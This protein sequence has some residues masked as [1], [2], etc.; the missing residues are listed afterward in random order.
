MNDIATPV[1]SK[2]DEFSEKLERGHSDLKIFIADFFGRS[3]A[4]WRFSKLEKFKM[5]YLCQCLFQSEHTQHNNTMS[6]D[7]YPP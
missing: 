7:M 6:H 4:V 3:K 5:E 2:L 1:S